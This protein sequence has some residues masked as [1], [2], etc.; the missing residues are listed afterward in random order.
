MRP[1]TVFRT[2][3]AVRDAAQLSQLIVRPLNLLLEDE[4]GEA[5][6]D[7]GLME[8]VEFRENGDEPDDDV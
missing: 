3:L 2:S 1:R 6:I 8:G 4:L 7:R 5:V